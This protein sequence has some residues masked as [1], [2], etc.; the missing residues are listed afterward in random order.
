LGAATYDIV[1]FQ[2]FFVELDAP[3]VITRS[4]PVTLTINLYNY[5]PQAQTIRVQLQPGDWYTLEASS[6]EIT[7]PANGVAT[8][9]FVIR[10]QK[11]GQFSLYATAQ[12]DA[13][14]DKV[15]LDVTVI[16]TQ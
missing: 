6:E 13:M 5:L 12:G 9:T 8:A 16:D 15:A 4:Q 3:E 10:P 14:A 1:V 2:D 7:I 11:T